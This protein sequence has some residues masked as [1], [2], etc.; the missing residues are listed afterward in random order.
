MAASIILAKKQHEKE[1]S[2]LRLVTSEDN[3]SSSDRLLAKARPLSVSGRDERDACCLG[4]GRPASPARLR[5]GHAAWQ[6]RDPVC[7]LTRRVLQMD[8][9]TLPHVANPPVELAG[10]R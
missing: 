4:T 1:F 9:S 8:F 10:E 3:F 6:T 7:C 5:C 2:N